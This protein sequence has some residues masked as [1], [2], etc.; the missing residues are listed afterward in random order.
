MSTGGSLGGY[1]NRYTSSCLTNT[2][3]RFCFGFL[4]CGGLLL[5]RHEPPLTRRFVVYYCSAVYRR[6]EAYKRH[7]PIVLDPRVEVLTNLLI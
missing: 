4:K 5:V 2:I 7:T 3:A 6:E 1:S